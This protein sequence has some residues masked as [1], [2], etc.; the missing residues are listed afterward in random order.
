MNLHTLHNTLQSVISSVQPEQ[1]ANQ[2]ET[3]TTV[4]VIQQNALNKPKIASQKPSSP[5][6]R[7]IV[8]HTLHNESAS[9]YNGVQ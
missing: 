7:T 1:P 5:P 4:I 3:K 9:L 8:L 6:F 2:P